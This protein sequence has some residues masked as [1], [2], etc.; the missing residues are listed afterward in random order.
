MKEEYEKL[1]SRL[2]HFTAV[3]RAYGK[4]SHLDPNLMLRLDNIATYADSI[5]HF[6]LVLTRYKSSFVQL[7]A[8]V[9]TKLERG[10]TKRVLESNADIAEVQD[11]LVKLSARI[12]AFI[13]RRQPSCSEVSRCS[14]P[15]PVRERDPGRNR[16]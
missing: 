10:T 15:M 12:E 2:A 6:T 13:V 11:L 5:D 9:E 7:A 16:C 3:T 1:E 14:R 4:R 8:S